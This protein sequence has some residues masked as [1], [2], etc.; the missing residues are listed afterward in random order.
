MYKQIFLFISLFDF[1]F[2]C[3]LIQTNTYTHTHKNTHIHTHYPIWYLS[4]RGTQ[5]RTSICKYFVF[6]S[7]LG[8]RQDWT[9]GPKFRY[10]VSY[11]WEFCIWYIFSEK[12]AVLN[13]FLLM[14][15]NLKFRTGWWREFFF[16]CLLKKTL[17]WLILI[18][19][20]NRFSIYLTIFMESQNQNQKDV[21]HLF[22]QLKIFEEK[23][24]LMC[25]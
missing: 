8:I 19:K 12:N 11:C 18:K 5:N 23:A 2:F 7:K 1:M 3:C 14:E 25:V 22:H 21:R 4:G 16:F 20:K 13:R 24:L 15:I 9:N 10:L 17:I 6:F